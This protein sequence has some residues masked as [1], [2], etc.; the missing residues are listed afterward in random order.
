M[1]PVRRPE[2]P[3]SQERARNRREA[4]LTSWSLEVGAGTR[5][6]G[7]RGRVW[8]EAG[9]PRARL[10][11]HRPPA[12]DGVRSEDD[13][14]M[15]CRARGQERRAWEGAGRAKPGDDDEVGKRRGEGGRGETR[16]VGLSPRGNKNRH[17]SSPAWP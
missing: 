4:T 15:K 14:G 11:V 1:P 10:Q 13:I 12:A 2:G 16:G 17:A 8:Q 5:W 7:P 9:R 3:P 6:L